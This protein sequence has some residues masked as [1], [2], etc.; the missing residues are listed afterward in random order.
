MRAHR[1][2]LLF[3]AIVGLGCGPGARDTGPNC[4]SSCTAL[5]FAQCHEDGSFDPPVL[6]G[7]DETC[8]AEH[9]C[10]VCV[11]DELYCGG[12]TGNDVLRCNDKGTDGTYVES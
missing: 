6:C 2:A 4:T 7:P 11:P 5:G 10:V 8:S 1:Y 9:G 3:W 12:N